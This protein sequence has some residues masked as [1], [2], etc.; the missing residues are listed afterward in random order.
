MVSNWIAFFSVILNF[1]DNQRKNS[2]IFVNAFLIPSYKVTIKVKFILKRIW[3]LLQLSH[4]III[5][6]MKLFVSIR[7]DLNKN[8]RKSIQNPL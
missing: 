8:L 1:N 3:L 5:A 7:W 6:E 4:T 2:S